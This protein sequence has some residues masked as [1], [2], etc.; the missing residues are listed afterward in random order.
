M[1]YSRGK[2]SNKKSKKSINTVSNSSDNNDDL[3]DSFSIN[4][5]TDRVKNN[6]PDLNLL[7]PIL[8]KTEKMNPVTKIMG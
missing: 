8:L 5:S 2:D 6:E 7:G 4:M 1:S 3:T